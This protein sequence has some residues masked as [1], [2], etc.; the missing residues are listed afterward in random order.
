MRDTPKGQSTIVTVPQ[1]D[2][3]HLPCLAF[4]GDRGDKTEQRRK[5]Q[6]PSATRAYGSG[7]QNEETHATAAEE[8]SSGGK[9]ATKAPFT[10]AWLSQVSEATKPQAQQPAVPTPDETAGTTP[11]SHA[12][13]RGGG[14]RQA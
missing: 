13:D 5:H 7:K 12:G 2:S 8:S 11:V 9:E 4:P 3:D 6:S 1:R 14:A 10:S